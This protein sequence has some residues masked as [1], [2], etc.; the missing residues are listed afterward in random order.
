MLRIRLQ[1]G[2]QRERS[3]PVS[4]VLGSR[5]LLRQRQRCIRRRCQRRPPVLP[6]PGAAL[7]PA[8]FRR[9]PG[10]RSRSISRAV[11]YTPMRTRAIQF[12]TANS[13][14][15]KTLDLVTQSMLV[16]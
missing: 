3:E 5:S 6:I 4:A 14:Q 13:Q 2:D 10:F 7:L 8:V 9:A 15:R 12:D 16:Q 11:Y 1:R